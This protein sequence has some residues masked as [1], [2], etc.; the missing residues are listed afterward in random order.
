MGKPAARM[1]DMHTCPLCNPGT[2]P[3]PHVGGPVSGPGVP[4]VLVGNMVAAVRYFPVLG[5]GMVAIPF[6]C[7]G[8]KG[9]L[10]R[11]VGLLA[12]ILCLWLVF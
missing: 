2:P 5:D 8:Q 10:M 6:V 7:F 4:T 11:I 1:G 3:P 9:S 12:G